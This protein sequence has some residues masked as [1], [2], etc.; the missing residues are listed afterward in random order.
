MNNQQQI[1]CDCCNRT[2]SAK[3]AEKGAFYVQDGEDLFLCE[4][5][6]DEEKPRFAVCDSCGKKA[7]EPALSYE[8]GPTFC[9]QCFDN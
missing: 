7:L 2:E 9:T 6:L 5:C 8:D 1:T 4:C 3:D